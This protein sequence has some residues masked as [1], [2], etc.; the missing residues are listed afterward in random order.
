MRRDL[1][2]AT[3]AHMLGFK[4]QGGFFR[5]AQRLAF[6]DAHSVPSANPGSR[7]I[8]GDKAGRLPASDLGTQK[9]MDDRPD[10]SGTP[11]GDE[12]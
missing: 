9:A 1:S 5:A 12:T 11:A 7:L 10:G 3:V 8:T 6:H 2:L 4:D